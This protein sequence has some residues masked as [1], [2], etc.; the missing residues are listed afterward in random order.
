MLLSMTTCHMAEILLK[1]EIQN[2]H[3]EAVQQILLKFGMQVN[4]G[5]G[6]IENDNRITGN[7][8]MAKSSNMG[9]FG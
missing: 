6:I 5:K 2:G 4:I 9:N 8:K 7:S 3:Q 1:W